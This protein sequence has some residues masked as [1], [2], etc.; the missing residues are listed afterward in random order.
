MKG[1]IS[2]SNAKQVSDH[3]D[4]YFEC[5]RHWSGEESAGYH[6]GIAK[7]VG[8]IFSNHKMLQN[9]SEMVFSALKLATSKT[10]RVLDAGCG[11]G[12]SS[13]ILAKKF[14]RDDI[15]IFG[16]TISQKQLDLGKKMIKKEGMEKK[17]KMSLDDFEQLPFEDN[18]FDAVYF[19]DS[20]CHGSGSSKEKT[21]KEVA[22][23]LKPGGRIALTDGFI[24]P[25]RGGAVI[26]KI[27]KNLSNAFGVDCWPNQDD[28]ITNLQNNGFEDIQFKDLTWV[29]GPSV[30]QTIYFKL[31]KV[32]Y[33]YLRKKLEFKDVVYTFKVAF[34]APILGLHPYFK[35]QLISAR[36][37]S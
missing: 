29:S 2:E 25:V 30:A 1:Q 37:A 3:Y 8:D 6:F 14:P 12:H 11:A 26:R 16:V 17:I 19:Q 36:K 33:S 32:F 27:S 4:D 10:L 24:F 31:P 13:R 7:K 23:V 22:R 21:I 18:F 28:F 15:T 34:L 9:A 35:Y 5:Y 20:I